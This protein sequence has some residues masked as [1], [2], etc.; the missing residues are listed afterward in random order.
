MQE[1]YYMCGGGQEGFYSN[2]QRQENFDFT[3]FMNDTSGKIDKVCTDIRNN[4]DV[5]ALANRVTPVV[6]QIGTYLTGAISVPFSVVES[7]VNTLGNGVTFVTDNVGKAAGSYL[8]VLARGITAGMGGLQ[9][10]INVIPLDYDPEGS[11]SND[12]A[13]FLFK[14]WAQS[15]VQIASIVGGILSIGGDISTAA[16]A[17]IDSSAR[18]LLGATLVDAASAALQ[19]L[20]RVINDPQF[21]SD[22]K[23]ARAFLGVKAKDAIIEA[24]DY[25]AKNK[26][27]DP[28]QTGQY[29]QVVANFVVPNANVLLARL[30]QLQPKVEAY[31]LAVSNLNAQNPIV[32]FDDKGNAVAKST[33]NQDV[34]ICT[35]T[36]Q[37]FMASA[38]RAAQ[39]YFDT[40]DPKKGIIGMIVDIRVINQDALNMWISAFP[41]T[42]AVIDGFAAS[43]TPPPTTVSVT[44]IA[45]TPTVDSAT[46]INK[47]R[48]AM[49]SMSVANDAIGASII[50]LQGAIKTVN[51]FV[52]DPTIL[53]VLPAALSS[54][55][56]TNYPTAIVGAFNAYITAST[57]TVS[58]LAAASTTTQGLIDS[59]NAAPT[60]S[61]TVAAAALKTASDAVIAIADAYN[62][63]ATKMNAVNTLLT[64]ISNSLVQFIPLYKGQAGADP[65]VYA[66]LQGASDQFTNMVVNPVTAYILVAVGMADKFTDILGNLAPAKE[67]YTDVD[68]QTGEKELPFVMSTKEVMGQAPVTVYNFKNIPVSMYS[69]TAEN[70]A[71]T[72]LYRMDKILYYI[73]RV[74]DGSII[75]YVEYPMPGM[76]DFQMYLYHVAGDEEPLVFSNYPIPGVI[77]Q[78]I[79]QLVGSIN[80]TPFTTVQNVK[81]GY[82]IL[83]DVQSGINQYVV[84]PVQGAFNTVVSSVSSAIDTV[85]KPIKA[86]AGAIKN[87]IECVVKGVAKFISELPK[88]PNAIYTVVKSVVETAVGAVSQ[89]ITNVGNLVG[90]IKD[91]VYKIGTSIFQGIKGV[92]DGSVGILSATVSGLI[93]TVK[94]I[95]NKIMALIKFLIALPGKIWEKLKS[96]GNAIA[97]FAT[98]T[99]D[100]VKK[101]ILNAFNF[102]P[103][104]YMERYQEP[105]KWYQSKW[106]YALLVLIAIAVG[107]FMYKKFLKR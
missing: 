23:N 68:L 67:S 90:T 29:F 35:T 22:L 107:Y 33:S 44:A 24:L 46:Y 102:E 57:T 84:S 2:C 61:P 74:P 37:F 91:N 15:C 30:S 39:L 83:D 36:L 5:N 13:V 9:S 32:N 8:Q 86:T 89:L 76:P 73:Q 97:G 100:K 25:I 17:T 95:K 56:T 12:Q 31:T 41:G 10:I 6:D 71:E 99:Y 7:G 42:K 60:A 81:E 49:G 3:S 103:F 50:N 14:N 38:G 34:T 1:G 85:M 47:L 93:D 43:T 11:S 75:E 79:D 18:N 87:A 40:K 63:A 62:A 58:Q 59:L 94:L 104:A 70:G 45:E 98:D 21:I 48:A 55:I 88:L 78:E 66:S 77:S 53:A 4:M 105:K 106:F 19:D 96:V 69:Q 16:A 64:Q 54:Q 72:Q 28:H 51:G 82:G 92:W 52:F 80:M 65:T 20:S 27:A 101:A 26:K